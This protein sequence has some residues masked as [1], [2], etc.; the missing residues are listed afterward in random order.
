MLNIFGVVRKASP[1]NVHL[2]KPLNIYILTKG[3]IRRVESILGREKTMYKGS[4]E[5]AFVNSWNVMNRHQKA[6]IR[7][8]DI[9][10]KG[11]K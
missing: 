2:N 7:G 3:K 10:T 5:H 11:S 6:S 8:Q 1:M 4:L 9:Y